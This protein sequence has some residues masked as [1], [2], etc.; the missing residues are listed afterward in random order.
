VSENILMEHVIP[1]ELL[2]DN[3]SD[4]PEHIL[5]DSEKSG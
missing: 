3:L 4:V 1:P 2:S 5:S